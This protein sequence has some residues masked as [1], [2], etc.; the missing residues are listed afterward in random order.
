LVAAVIDAGTE[1]HPQVVAAAT[2]LAG[3]AAAVTVLSD[4]ETNFMGS[5]TKVASFSIGVALEL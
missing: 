2:P 4:W 1:A 5:A 3:G